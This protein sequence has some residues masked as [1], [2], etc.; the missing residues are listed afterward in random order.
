M[1][2]A[3][4]TLESAI[5]ERLRAG[6]VPPRR[7]GLLND[8]SR[9][10]SRSLADDDGAAESKWYRH[11]FYGWNIYSLYDGQPFPGLAE[12]LRVKDAARVD[13]RGPRHRARRCSGCQRGLRPM[14]AGRALD[15]RGA[16]SARW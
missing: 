16:F 14:A 3:A 4:E 2:A 6:A 12:A 11:V 15:R 5:D 7:R 9:G 13:A 8:A 10:W 1:R